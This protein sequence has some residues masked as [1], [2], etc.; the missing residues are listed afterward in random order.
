ML[1]LLS[2]LLSSFESLVAVLLVEKNTIKME[3]V[4]SVLLQNEVFRQENRALSSG[5]DSAIAVT[6]GGGRRRPRDRGS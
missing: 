5:G 1:I 4:T 2:S 3:E 6:G